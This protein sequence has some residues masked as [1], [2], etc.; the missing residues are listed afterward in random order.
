[1][2]QI[3]AIFVK[4]AR[5]LWPHITGFLVLMLLAALLDPTYTVQDPSVYMLLSTLLPLASCALIVTVIHEEKLPGDRQYWLTRP[6]SWKHLLAAKTLFVIAFINLPLLLSHVAVW[7]ALGVPPVEHL[8]ALL[9][10]QVFFTVFYVLPVAVLAA[11]T[12]NIGQVILAALLLF[13]AGAV[14]L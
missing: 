14:L 6:I 2:T 3:L 9:W 10:K 8:P 13:V 1:M 5:H 11:I 12:R 4:D 7:L